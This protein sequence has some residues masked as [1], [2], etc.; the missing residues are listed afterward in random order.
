MHTRVY[1]STAQSYD[2]FIDRYIVVVFGL[3]LNDDVQYCIARAG[4]DAGGESAVCV[5]ARCRRDSGVAIVLDECCA[6]KR[7]GVTST[8]VAGGETFVTQ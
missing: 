6:V 3:P 8:L 7:G 4:D 2:C 5:D 1:W